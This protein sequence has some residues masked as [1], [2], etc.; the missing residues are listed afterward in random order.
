STED[1]RMSAEAA[2]QIAKS[3]AIAPPAGSVY[4]TAYLVRV[5]RGA[6]KREVIVEFADASA[7]ASAGYAE[8][9]TRRFLRDDEPPQHLVVE[10]A[11]T[12][13]NQQGPDHPVDHCGGDG[14]VRLS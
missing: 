13:R 14:R 4:G 10:T 7:V 3:G 12:V 6:S 5:M 11:G 9:V 8:E 2:W 1:G